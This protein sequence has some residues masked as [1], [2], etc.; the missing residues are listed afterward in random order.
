MKKIIATILILAIML[1]FAGCNKNATS[2]AD[3]GY[4]SAQSEH[5]KPDEVQE[6]SVVQ[7]SSEPQSNSQISSNNTAKN[8]DTTSGID[9]DNSSTQS[10]HAK[11]DDTPESGA[12]QHNSEPQPSSQTSSDDAVKTETKTL[13]ATNGDEIKISL[14]TGSNPK[15]N[16]SVNDKEIFNCK[17]FKDNADQ[18][19]FEKDFSLEAINEYSEGY[20]N[21][22]YQFKWGVIL[23]TAT[24]GSETSYWASAKHQYED[25]VYR[26]QGLGTL[27]EKWGLLEL[28]DAGKYWNSEKLAEA[29]VE[30]MYTTTDY[31]LTEVTN[32]SESGYND[33]KYAL[34]RGNQLSPSSQFQKI[35]EVS[36]KKR[37][38]CAFV[39]RCCNIFFRNTRIGLGKSK[40]CYF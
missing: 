3:E 15:I 26:Q 12:V 28:N 35:Y 24:E 4:S 23:S 8:E 38:Y 29:I 9:K 16:V 19:D 6:S 20:I 31:T 10:E 32:L 18:Y 1:C 17:D 40:T 33:Q 22:A 5:T 2:S 14:T 36:V 39:C 7:H 30:T 34:M 11:P 13:T 27:V 21:W 37:G 25:N